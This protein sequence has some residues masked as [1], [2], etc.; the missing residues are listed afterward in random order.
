[1]GTDRYAKI[2]RILPYTITERARGAET[3]K[4]AL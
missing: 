1:M 4:S 3:I 2:Q